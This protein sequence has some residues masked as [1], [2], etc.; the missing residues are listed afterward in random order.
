MV[1][2]LE[3]QLLIQDKKEALV[4]ELLIKDG[5]IMGGLVLAFACI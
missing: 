5:G 3:V 4:K 2:I 1:L